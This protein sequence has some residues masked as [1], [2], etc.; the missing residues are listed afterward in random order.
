MPTPSFIDHFEPLH[1]LLSC[2]VNVPVVFIKLLQMNY[3][4]FPTLCNSS[5]SAMVIFK[6]ITFDFGMFYFGM[7]HLVC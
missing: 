4:L 5:Y 6:N 2:F 3:C 7:F 1:M